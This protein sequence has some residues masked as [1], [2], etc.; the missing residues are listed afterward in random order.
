VKLELF[1]SL[2]FTLTNKPLI[3]QLDEAFKRY[4]EH[5]PAQGVNQVSTYRFQISNQIVLIH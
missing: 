1:Y 4:S 5:V 2:V 3:N